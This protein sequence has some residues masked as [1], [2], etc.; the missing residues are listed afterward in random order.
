MMITTSHGSCNEIPQ[1]LKQLEFSI[2]AIV[3]FLANFP[4][5][6]FGV[7]VLS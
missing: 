4:G 6:N 7:S 2:L 5:M 1:K 3:Q